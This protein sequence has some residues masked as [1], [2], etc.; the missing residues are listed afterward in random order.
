MRV[1]ANRSLFGAR[2]SSSHPPTLLLISARARA[3]AAPLTLVHPH[4]GYCKQ[5]DACLLKF[6]ENAAFSSSFIEKIAKHK[7]GKRENVFAY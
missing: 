7:T 6:P 2:F 3:Y 1:V 5:E 4:Y